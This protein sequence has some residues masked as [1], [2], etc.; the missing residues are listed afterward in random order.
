MHTLNELDINTWRSFR[1]LGENIPTL[2]T[3]EITQQVGLSAA[4]FRVLMELN[5]MQQNEAASNQ[6]T[7]LINLNWEKSRL[8]HL[9]NRMEKKNLIIRSAKV[10]KLQEV[11]MSQAGEAALK[12]A[13]PVRDKYVKQYFCDLLSHQDKKDLLR[14][15]EKLE[16]QLNQMLSR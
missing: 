5:F 7:L 16:G 6:K 3:Q 15:C 14:I 12:A 2:L 4:E 13:I 11:N 8:S 10:G 1:S 9:L